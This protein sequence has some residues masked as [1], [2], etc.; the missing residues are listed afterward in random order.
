MIA[1]ARAF[2]Y[3]IAARNPRLIEGVIFDRSIPS[4]RP[5]VAPLGRYV[6]DLAGAQLTY[7]K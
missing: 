7:D 4:D 1:A 3:L 6:D 5:S 2:A